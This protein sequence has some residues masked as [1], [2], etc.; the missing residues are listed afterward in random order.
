VCYTSTVMKWR[1]HQRIAAKAAQDLG[2]DKCQIDKLVQGVIQ[3]DQTRKKYE[4]HHSGTHSVTMQHIW[5]ARRAVL[6]GELTKAAWELGRALHYIHDK[7]VPGGW[8]HNSIEREIS[9]LKVPQEAIDNARKSAVCSFRCAAQCVRSTKTKHDAQNAMWQAVEHSTILIKA[10]FGD[11]RISNAF[12][13]QIRKQKW[14]YF[15]VI[16]TLSGTSLIGIP[17]ILTILAGWPWFPS[18]LLGV[19]STLI[20][21]R[22]SQ[23]Y[24]DLRFES[25]WFDSGSEAQPTLF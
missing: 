5:N 25:K 2:L 8:Q 20:V 4:R 17:I 15:M 12:A 16:I 10:V 3:P 21:R 23:R 6:N 14:I 18:A 9:S 22:P 7:S 11:V 1:D 19:I 24:T 13:R